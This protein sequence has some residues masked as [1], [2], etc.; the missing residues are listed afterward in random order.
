MLIRGGT[1]VTERAASAADIRVDGERIAEVGPGLEQR[2]GE[3]VFDASGLLV[4]PGVI[5]P[6]THFSLD[7]G[8]G[9]TADDWDNPLSRTPDL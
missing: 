9:P 5:D 1:V 7:S 3:E 2:R 4:L 8:T 6:H